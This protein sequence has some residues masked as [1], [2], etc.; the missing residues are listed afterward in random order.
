MLLLMKATTFALE[1]KPEIRTFG[2]VQPSGS[3]IF[4]QYVLAKKKS[5]LL[6]EKFKCTLPQY[7]NQF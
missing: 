7:T 2:M 4:G 5:V 6:I 1:N 3:F